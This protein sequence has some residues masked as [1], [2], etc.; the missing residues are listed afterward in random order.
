MKNSFPTESWLTLLED[1]LCTMNGVLDCTVWYHWYVLFGTN[2]FIWL[3]PNRSNW[4]LDLQYA[5]SFV[6]F[7]ILKKKRK[8]KNLYCPGEPWRAS[9]CQ[10]PFSLNTVLIKIIHDRIN[11]DQY[12]PFKSIFQLFSIVTP[13]WCT[14]NRVL[15]C[16]QWSSSG[17]IT[18]SV[19]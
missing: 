19:F 16:V 14:S 9:W 2:P 11:T 7:Y 5:M 6:I 10:S 17:I 15:W 3:P 13:C 12:P 18:I 8:E 4:K 1:V